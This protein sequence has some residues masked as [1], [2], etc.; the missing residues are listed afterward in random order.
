MPFDPSTDAIKVRPALVAAEAYRAVF[1]R[2]GLLLELGWLPLLLLLAAMLLPGYLLDYTRFGAGFPDLVRQSEL[3]FGPIDLVEA[4][5]A[6]LCLNAFAVRWHQLMLFGGDRTVPHP[7][8]LRGWARFLLYTLALYGVSASLLATALIAGASSASLGGASGI[9]LAAAAIALVAGVW[10]A[11]ARCSMLFPAA[12]YGAPLGLGSAWRLLAGNTWRLVGA[13]ILA[14][15]PFILA[16]LAVF[17]ALLQALHVDLESTGAILPLGLFILRGVVDTVSNFIGVALGA[18]V[19]SS[20]YRRLTQP[21][22]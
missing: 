6:F 12:A 22:L 2:L 11:T 19:L 21:A 1:G 4:V 9:G 7:L 16:V 17:S 3:G 15:L 5:T 13:G 10:L 8:F 20:F 14:C 18:T